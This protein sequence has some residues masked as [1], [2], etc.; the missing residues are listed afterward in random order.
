MSYNPVLWLG[1]S[2]ANNG[3]PNTIQDSYDQL[4]STANVFGQTG[5]KVFR[6]WSGVIEMA[7]PRLMNAGLMTQAQWQENVKFLKAIGDYCRANNI[8]ISVE[9]NFTWSPLWT[10]S[11][12]SAAATAGLP[13]AYVDGGEA[14]LNVRDTPEDLTALA[15]TMAGNAK[16]IA[17]AFP[18]VKIGD[19][20]PPVAKA[21]A[22]WS[23]QLRNWWAT[24]N[25]VA[26][27]LGAPR[28]SYFLADIAWNGPDTSWLKV[29]EQTKADA[30]AAGLSFGAFV[31]GY[32]DSIVGEQ[33][34]AQAQQNLA[35][36]AANAVIDPEFLVLESWSAALPNTVTPVT[37]AGSMAWLGASI[38][39]LFPL[40][41]DGKVTAGG[42]VAVTALPQMVFRVGVTTALSGIA[43]QLAASDVSANGKA[44]LLLVSESTVLTAQLSGAGQITG[45]GT[46][47]LALAGTAAELTAMLKTLR[48]K[49]ATGGPDTLTVTA[50]NALGQA[51]MARVELLATPT[52][53]TSFSFK[54]DTGSRTWASAAAQ[55]GMDGK[56][57][58]ET[59]T[60]FPDAVDPVTGKY[61]P[62][63]TLLVH[64][65]LMDSKLAQQNGR[66]VNP[67]AQGL[68][69]F[70]PSNNN[71]KPSFRTE[72]LLKTVVT[73]SPTTGQVRTESST[74]K[75][76]QA[77]GAWN[78]LASGGS[79]VTQYN[80]G[81]N[82]NW[83]PEWG[84]APAS[85]TTIFAGNGAK[86]E[87]AYY[88]K[89]GNPFLQS[90]LIWSTAGKGLWERTDALPSG[91]SFV[92]GLR[93]VTQYNTGDNPNWDYVGRSD[94][95]SVATLFRDGLAL[96]QTLLGTNGSRTFVQWN[97]DGTQPWYNLAQWFNSAGQKAQERFQFRAADAI[98]ETLLKYDVASGT[99]WQRWDSPRAGGY[100]LTQYDVANAETWDNFV[101]T[102]NAAN[103]ILSLVY[104]FKPGQPYLT[105]T[106]LFD[107]ASGK[108]QQETAR[109]SDGRT[110]ITDVDVKGTE[111]WT[112]KVR[113]LDASIRLASERF[114]WRAGEG[115]VSTE[116]RY[117]VATGAL[118]QRWDKP[119]EGGYVLT[120]YDTTGTAAM[121][122]FT[123][124][125]SAANK[126]IELHQVF[127]SGNT[128]S[129][130]DAWYDPVNSGMRE[131]DTYRAD[132]VT[133]DIRRADGSVYFTDTLPLSAASSLVHRSGMKFLYASGASETLTGTAA[134]DFFVLG[135]KPTT[136]STLVEIAGFQIGRDVLALP[137]ARFGDWSRI[138]QS[139]TAVSGG[140]LLR[141]VAGNES[142]LLRGLAPQQLSKSDV[143]II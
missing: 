65:P 29:V 27:S 41:N 38:S 98:R 66:L 111:R 56:I 31:N 16:I 69:L 126:M 90:I 22:A 131:I 116:F 139:A 120:Q 105:I 81:S 103:Q 47:S 101:Q 129:K 45:N 79:V 107:T 77:G 143:S 11:W 80:D 42:R 99:L 52:A 61:R 86:V 115:L 88:W 18:T 134:S 140:M 75:A 5:A 67:V 21:Q 37:S 64:S 25:A 17:Q 9:D 110:Q 91:S 97:Y 95:S 46:N 124:V 73:F 19:V 71:G 1:G 40:Y 108:M 137:V 85:V 30:V 6:M 114:D 59:Y 48:V 142:V 23:Q 130:V 36:L 133:I 7:S 128:V 58:S 63:T 89:P 14:L 104:T 123:Q 32:S 78:P 125:V 53:G 117:D 87:E 62:L 112:Q 15:K 74:I 51:G 82:P 13:I 122:Y 76:S 43:M 4:I 8:V 34:T 57:R 33:W 54:N 26:D 83:K 118:Y 93:L 60:W 127:R 96:E 136:G 119:P 132:I 12:T 39:R 70:D 24:Y 55:V 100:V 49:A 113:I 10:K 92:T 3:R 84:S 138:A 121:A 102:V 44:A 28:F 50:F 109:L 135:A 68:E 72:T 2:L 94:Q 141:S 35:R 20:Q 106:R